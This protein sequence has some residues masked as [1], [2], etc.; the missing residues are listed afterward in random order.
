M[1][2]ILSICLVAVFALLLIADASFAAPRRGR[3]G[4]RA[5]N[6]DATCIENQEN[7]YAPAGKEGKPGK[8]RHRKRI[9][10]R[11]DEDGDGKLSEEERAKAQAARRKMLEKFDTDGDGKLS[12]EERTEM[13]RHRRGR[14]GRKGKGAPEGSGPK[15]EAF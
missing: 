7:P 11:F 1:K 2:K 5:R 10:K 3:A 14:R 6:R 4:N 15:P 8:G 9:L 12:P 13:P